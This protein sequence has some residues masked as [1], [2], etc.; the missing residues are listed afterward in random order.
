VHVTGAKWSSEGAPCRDNRHVHAWGDAHLRGELGG[1]GAHV[2][3]DSCSTGAACNGWMAGLELER[4]G[5]GVQWMDGR[6]RIRVASRR[7]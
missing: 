7:A 4:H 1:L 5:G 2:G 3:Q 6:V